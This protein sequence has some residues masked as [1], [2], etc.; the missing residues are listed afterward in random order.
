MNDNPLFCNK[1]GKSCCK[2]LDNDPPN[3]QSNYGL[4]NAQ[5]TTGYFS[6]CFEDLIEITFSICEECLFNTFKVMPKTKEVSATGVSRSEI[7]DLKLVGSK[8]V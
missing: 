7:R 2:P 6:E 1:C 3:I 4:N 5:F 8:F